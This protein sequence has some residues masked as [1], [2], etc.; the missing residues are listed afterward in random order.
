[1]EESGLIRRRQGIGTIICRN[2][3]RINSTM[4]I[5]ESVSEMIQ[6]KGMKP[7][8]MQTTIRKM[9]ATKKLAE[10]LDLEL[11][12]PVISLDRVR[13]A[14]GIPV[15]YTKDFVP[16]YLITENFFDDLQTGSLYVYLEGKLGIE[17]TNNMLKIEP[18]KAPKAIA[19][20]LAIRPGILLMFLRQ[21]DMNPD[22][23]PVLYSEEYFIADRFE[24]IIIRRRKVRS[25]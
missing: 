19:Q 22:N 25:F 10:Q 6:G 13:T 17:L 14:D 5:N 1:M 16:K 23:F 18:L 21:T 12:E 20:K 11:G 3:N 2:K 9:R 15:A 8:S 7:G 24:F 4:D